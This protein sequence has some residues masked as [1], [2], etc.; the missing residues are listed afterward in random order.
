M[1]IF[2]FIGFHYFQVEDSNAVETYV[3]EQEE[4]TAVESFPNQTCEDKSEQQGTSEIVD[5]KTQ[6]PSNQK[7][8]KKKRNQKTPRRYQIYSRIDV[9]CRFFF[10]ATFLV[11]YIL[12]WAGSLL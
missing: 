4:A 9:W 3:D 2:S 7:A 1:P 6:R 10:P 11:F 12:Y 5:I 8:K